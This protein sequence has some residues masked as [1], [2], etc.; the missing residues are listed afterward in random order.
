[1]SPTKYSEPLKGAEGDQVQS[2]DTLQN[3]KGMLSA[4]TYSVS[5]QSKPRASFLMNQAVI[6]GSPLEIFRGEQPQIQVTKEESNQAEVVE[7]EM[8][9]K[10]KDKLSP[11]K[12]D[13]KQSE[14]YPRRTSNSLLVSVTDAKE[15]VQDSEMTF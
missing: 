4:D 8:G 9:R 1:M 6:D 10:D 5:N 13:K 12:I 14:E 11:K 15:S 7:V 2:V 3:L